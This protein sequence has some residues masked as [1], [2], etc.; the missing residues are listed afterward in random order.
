V[1]SRLIAQE[2]LAVIS[3]YGCMCCG[4]LECFLEAQSD[5]TRLEVIEEIQVELGSVE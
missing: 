3:R 2:V 5:S 4:E 1:S